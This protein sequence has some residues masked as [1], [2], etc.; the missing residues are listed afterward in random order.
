MDNIGIEK[1]I[2]AITG[3]SGKTTT[4]EMV[5]S[6]IQRRWKVFKSY[7]N[8]NDVWFTSQYVKQIDPT[9]DALV[10][11][12]GMT[13]AGN[14]TE[15]CKLIQPNIGI[16]TNVGIAHIGN[17]ED[18]EFGVIA[19]KS[20]LIKGMKS[21]GI[22]F[23]N[24]DDLNSKLLDK[25]DFR[26]EILSIGIQNKANYQAREIYYTENG[27]NFRVEMDGMDCPFYI[28]IFGKHNVYNALFAIAVSHRLGL[29]INDI[30][31]GLENF[32]QTFG[33]LTIYRLKNEITIIND[34]FN[35][36]PDAMKEAI[37]VLSNIG[38]DTKIAILGCMFDLGI[39]EEQ[40]YRDI[41]S[42]AGSC[43]IDYL[44]TVGEGTKIIGEAANQSGIADENVKHFHSIDE[45]HQ[46]LVGQ[47]KEKTTVLIKGY[48]G[49]ENAMRVKMIDTAMFL[50]DYFK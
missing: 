39:H 25:G 7:E 43:K 30:R 37:N 26:G 3:S 47:I 13:H 1:P 35:A 10:L 29:S 24:E 23:L 21:D 16:I 5:S 11:E 9:Y 20:E 12:Y 44:Y 2:I 22:L 46:T 8:G 38:K 4:K 18:Q 49:M 15:H 45:L 50:R 34:T 42:Y 14:I 41:G 6:I 36:K 27:M 28:P 31:L 48:F 32:Y 19:A 40:A 17:F 33:R